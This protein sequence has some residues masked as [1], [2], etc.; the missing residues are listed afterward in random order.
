M[1]RSKRQEW[2]K[3]QEKTCR[4]ACSETCWKHSSY[5][6]PTSFPSSPQGNK[7]ARGGGGE[8][9]WSPF[10]PS[11]GFFCSYTACSIRWKDTLKRILN[12]QKHL[13]FETCSKRECIKQYLDS[14]IRIRIP[15]LSLHATQVIWNYT[16]K[17]GWNEKCLFKTFRTHPHKYCSPF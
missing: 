13:T 9:C 3:E 5:I 8:S 7:G 2:S 10:L 17:S 16:S 4:P 6:Y 14:F 12:R 1:F 11:S 15:L